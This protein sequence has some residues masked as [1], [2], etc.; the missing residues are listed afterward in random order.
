L[1]NE[2]PEKLRV[3]IELG[4]AKADFEGDVNKVFEL[5]VR[6]LTQIYPD[7]EVIRKIVYTPDIIKLAE[8]VEGLVE[9]TTE[10]P[11]FSSSFDA[12]ARDAICLALL[13]AYLGKALGKLSNDALSTKH[14]ARIVGKARKTISNEVP[15]LISD[16]LIERT[17]D[18]E[19]RLTILGIR[20]TESFIEQYKYKK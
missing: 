5:T 4:D 8:K 20:N 11:V 15:R 18:G 7:L 12:P 10:G 17:S 16:G 2:E 6:F 3:H 19:Y 9:I 14:L 1:K 13:G